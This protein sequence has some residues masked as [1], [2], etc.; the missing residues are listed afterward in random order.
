M[1]S[2]LPISPEEGYKEERRLL[3]TKY[4]RNYQIATAYVERVTN[5][6]SIKS[7]DGES[8]QRFSIMLTTCKNAL[9]QIGYLSKIENPDSLQKIME[10]LPF[11]LRQK[12][13]DVLDDITKVKQHE[14]T[15]EDIAFFVEK[16]A[17]AC[18][19]PI[20]DKILRETKS[21][22]SV[23]KNTK[24]TRGSDFATKGNDDNSP[25]TVVKCPSC[26]SG[27]WLSRCDNFKKRSIE[28]QFKIVRSLKL[29]DNCLIPGHVGRSCQKRSFCK[30]DG[31]ST[32]TLHSW[33][34]PCNQKILLPFFRR[35]LKLLDIR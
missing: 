20:F 1:R 30:I 21:E 17:R 5:Y 31:A 22:N 6:P 11:G 3:K 15:I 25:H 23:G 35:M 9:K 29:C 18:N 10:K 12:W 34:F 27:H 28:E 24:S 13:C 7:E 33:E 26:G 32:S 8:L 2:C 19:H 14:I 4:R 16:R